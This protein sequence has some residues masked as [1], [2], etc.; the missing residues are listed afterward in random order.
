MP[1]HY[2]KIVRKLLLSAIF[3][4]LLAGAALISCK[5]MAFRALYKAELALGPRSSTFPAWKDLPFPMPTSFYLYHVSNPGEVARG[6]K[7]LLK[8]KGPFTFFEKHHKEVLA[9]N[10]NDTVTYRQAKTWFFDPNLSNGSLS[11]E[12]TVLNPVAAGIGQIVKDNVPESLRSLINVVL[13][14]LEE[15]L[16]V[17]T[18]VADIMFNGVSDP[19][20]EVLENIPIVRKFFP[21]GSVA[22]KFGFLYGHNGSIYGDGI[23]NMYVGQEDIS[24]MGHVHSWNF[25]TQNVFRGQCGKVRGS[26]GE[27]FP[28]GRSKTY[29]ELYSPDLCRNLRF[30]F[31]QT[32]AVSGTLLDEFIADSLLFANSSFNKRNKCFE[33]ESASLPSGVFNASLC[34]FG[35]PL[36]ISQPHFFQADSYYASLVEGISP[37]SREKHGSFLRIEPVTGV[38]VGVNVRMQVN[39]LIGPVEGLSMFQNLSRSFFPIM[40]SENAVQVPDDVAFQIKVLSNFEYIVAGAGWVCVGG[41]VA[42]L[43]MLALFRVTEEE[44]RGP[45]FSQGGLEDTVSDNVFFSHDE[46]P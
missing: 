12:I 28:P 31:N 2:R 46:E 14:G 16:F 9:W 25:S 17:N 44:E 23:W 18:T 5:G 6:A 19:L 32:V 30:N 27:F 38:S 10:R 37:P 42:A 39:M 20:F 3:V 13:R 43:I 29:V 4:V 11:D 45:L 8:E 24:K 26:A 34:K 35:V 36:F 22:D 1:P 33:D 41:M 7:P 40:W 21:P 15:R